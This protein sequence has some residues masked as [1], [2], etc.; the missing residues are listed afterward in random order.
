MGDGAQGRTGTG[1][2]SRRVMTTS[3]SEW[4]E[5]RRIADELQLKI[6][7][8]SME[9]RDRWEA[10]K[11]RIADLE[12]KLARAGERAAEAVQ[13]EMSAVGKTLHKLREDLAG[14]AK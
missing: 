12:H 2:A 3:H 7:L 13:N 8:G 9:L 5:L 14:S 10:V 11:P 4:T 1:N 6:H